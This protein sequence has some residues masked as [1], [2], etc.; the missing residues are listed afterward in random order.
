MNWPHGVCAHML[1]GGA[2]MPSSGGETSELRRRLH[3]EH[4]EPAAFLSVNIRVTSSVIFLTASVL[5]GSVFG[6]FSCCLQ[7]LLSHCCCL[8]PP[9]EMELAVR[10]FGN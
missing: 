3:L 4:T 5:E 7:S 8:N 1:S 2:H 6:M 10:M 9:K